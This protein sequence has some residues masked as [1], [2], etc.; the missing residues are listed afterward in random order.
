[1][2]IETC[3]L[4]DKEKV[5]ACE[6]VVKGKAAFVKTSTGFGPGGATAEDVRVLKETAAGRTRVKAS[7]GI[8]TLDDA[9]RMIEAGATRI[10]TSSGVRIV[11]D[12]KR[13]LS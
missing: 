5:E 9:L 11:E 3:Y 12:S 6:L 7:G 2:I 10:G 8:K 1:M 4:T 13:G